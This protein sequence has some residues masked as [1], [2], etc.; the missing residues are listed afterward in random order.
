M[1]LKNAMKY[2]QGCILFNYCVIDKNVSF[3]YRYIF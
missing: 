1:P 3:F 2:K